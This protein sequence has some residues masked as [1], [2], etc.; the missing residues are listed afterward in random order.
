LWEPLIQHITPAKRMNRHFLVP[1]CRS[2]A[3]NAPLR[4]TKHRNAKWSK[5]GP[6]EII[7][8]G[9]GHQRSPFTYQL[10]RILNLK[11]HLGCPH[12]RLIAFS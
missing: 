5:D 2:G 4:A 11:W 3:I 10:Q 9:D 6:K 7:A 12:I 1:F 8:A